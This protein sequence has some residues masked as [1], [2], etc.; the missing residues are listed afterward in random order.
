MPLSDPDHGCRKWRTL[1]FPMV[2]SLEARLGSLRSQWFGSLRVAN[3]PWKTRWSLI[4]PVNL[5]TPWMLREFQQQT[6][7]AHYPQQQTQTFAKSRL[8][9]AACSTV[10]L[11]IKSTQQF[12]FGATANKKPAQVVSKAE[13]SLSTQ[14]WML[15]LSN[16]FTYW[17]DW[18]PVNPWIMMVNQHASD[19]QNPD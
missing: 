12:F 10:S 18:I 2:C 15:T 8:A 19:T 13:P 1:E 16:C 11:L 9:Q 6:W 5:S 3:S 7:Q 17:C 14:F 4:C